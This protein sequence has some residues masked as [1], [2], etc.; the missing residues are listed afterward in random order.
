M[1]FSSLSDEMNQQLMA[2]PLDLESLKVV[3][4]LG[5]WKAPGPD[6][7]NGEFFK[8]TWNVSGPKL[9]SFISF[10][11]T[12]QQKLGLFNCTYVVPIPKHIGGHTRP[13]GQLSFVIKLIRSS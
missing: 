3:R 4:S 13:I 1:P 2:S 5:S 8:A 7:V 12:R 11:Y 6:N 9:C 10:F